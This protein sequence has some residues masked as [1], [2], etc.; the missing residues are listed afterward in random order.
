MAEQVSN[1]VEWFF[2]FLGNVCE[3]FYNLLNYEIDLSFIGLHNDEKL[4]VVLIGGGL[5]VI[6]L[7]KIIQWLTPIV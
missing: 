1:A 4:I 5:L 6:I 2:K 7:A 3:T